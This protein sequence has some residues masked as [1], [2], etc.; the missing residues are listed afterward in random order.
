MEETLEIYKKPYD[1][2]CPQVCLD[3]N[4]LVVTDSVDGLK[5]G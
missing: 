4:V 2:Q 3:E 5:W 1:S